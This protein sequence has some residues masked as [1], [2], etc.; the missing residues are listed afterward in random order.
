ME[1]EQIAPM[2]LKTISMSST[3]RPTPTITKKIA[4]V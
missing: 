4:K 2:K 3:D 1:V